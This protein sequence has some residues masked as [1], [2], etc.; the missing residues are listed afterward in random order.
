MPSHAEE[1]L[2]A[3]VVDLYDPAGDLLQIVTD[4]P[5]AMRRVPSACTGEAGRTSAGTPGVAARVRGRARDW[6][7]ARM[8]RWLNVG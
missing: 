3:Q 4:R 6:G 2:K 1:I 8:M 5:G 7:F